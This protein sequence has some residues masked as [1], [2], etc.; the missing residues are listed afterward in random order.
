MRNP[1]EVLG[2]SENA[3]DEEIKKAY[4]ELVK[5][6]HPDKYAGNPLSE[7]AAEKMKEINEAY[8]AITK[9]G[10]AKHSYGGTSS[11][12]SYGNDAAIYA[13]VRQM[14]NAGA[15]A[16]AENLLNGISVR[17]AEW[18]YLM[19]VV[20]LKKGWYDM[21]NQHFTRAVTLD[22]NN[23]EYRNAKNN[24]NMQSGGY[25]QMGNQGGYQAGCTPCDMCTGLMCTDC[26]CEC[27]GGDFIRCC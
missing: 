6:Y 5:K 22:P 13:R 17:G 20:S 9:N 3:T 21:A 26:C 12:G 2:V 23:L 19:G 8:D 11:G 4:R 15:V 14:L 10:G 1:Y 24:M 18:H 7:L 25:R 16:E 27:M